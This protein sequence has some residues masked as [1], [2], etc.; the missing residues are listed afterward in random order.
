MKRSQL[1][2]TTVLAIGLAHPGMAQDSAKPASD[3]TKA[4][5]AAVLNEL[6]FD[7][8]QA[9]EEAAKGFSAPL[10]NDGVVKNE[11]GDTVAANDR[12]RERSM[13]APSRRARPTLKC[14]GCR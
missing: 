6:P 2:L 9:F 12:N 1:L 14:S 5:N 3:A 13:S 7:N 10:E 8:T 4:A 11:K